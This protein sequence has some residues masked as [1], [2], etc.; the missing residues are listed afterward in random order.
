MSSFSRIP[1]VEGAVILKL[2]G[3]ET[4]GDPLDGILEAVGE[5]IHGIDAPFVAGSVV[6]MVQYP[7]YG[8]ITHVHVGACH[9]DLGPQGPGAA[10]KLSAFHS[11]EEIEVLPGGPVPVGA[12]PAGFL[13]GALYFRTSSAVRSQT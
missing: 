4:V 6:R 13:K 1:V 12:V 7:V 11:A 5:V 9:I 2:E 3:A 8:R 10:G